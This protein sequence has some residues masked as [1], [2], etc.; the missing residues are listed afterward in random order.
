DEVLF[1]CGSIERAGR[2]RHHYVGKARDRSESVLEALNH[3]GWAVTELE[4]F[5]GLPPQPRGGN[6]ESHPRA[7]RSLQEEQRD[8]FRRIVVVAPT[9]AT[10][11]LGSLE[12][13][14][15]I[16]VMKI[17]DGEQNRIHQTIVGV[18]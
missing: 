5:D 18:P 7:E 14:I 11:R 2:S 15:D 17:G 12:D 6:R 3:R 8:D 16:A 13:S 10:E 1:E 4:Y 9:G